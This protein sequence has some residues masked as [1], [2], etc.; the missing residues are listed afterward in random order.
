MNQA[1]ALKGFMFEYYLVLVWY[2]RN[3][4]CKVPTILELANQRSK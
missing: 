3:S 2:P 4:N 1:L